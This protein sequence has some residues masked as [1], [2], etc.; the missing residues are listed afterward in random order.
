M[1]TSVYS[2]IRQAII[3]K[4]QVVATYDGCVREMGP[5]V[6]GT[7]NGRSQ[8]LFYQFGGS[9]KSGLGPAGSGA[10][11]RCIPIEGLSHVS[12]REGPWHTA[13]TH[14][15]EQSCVDLID[16]EVSH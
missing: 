14:S 4:Q 12:V 16:A 15:R 8:A 1:A 13:P 3:K 6:I 5:H 11:W 2:L 10:N 9:S 7:N